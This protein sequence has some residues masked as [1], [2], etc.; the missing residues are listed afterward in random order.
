MRAILAGPSTPSLRAVESQETSTLMPAAAGSPAVADVPASSRTGERSGRRPRASRPAAERAAK[1]HPYINREL[2][3]LD[4][5][6]RVLFEAGDVRNPILE[7]IN[8][9]TIFASIPGARYEAARTKEAMAS[10]SSTENRREFLIDALRC[11][12]EIG[13]RPDADRVGVR[14]TASG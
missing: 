11:Y 10:I 2:A 12:Q 3:W 14:L 8:F 9:V 5:S 7:R 4:Y 1:K 13:A 6:A